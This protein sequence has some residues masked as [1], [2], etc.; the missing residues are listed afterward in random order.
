MAKAYNSSKFN[1]FFLKYKDQRDS[2]PQ[3]LLLQEKK[4][5]LKEQII[6][7]EFIADL[8]QLDHEILTPFLKEYIYFV[9]SF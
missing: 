5:S 6:N 4:N 3:P 9:D 2:S 7:N 8:F 1:N